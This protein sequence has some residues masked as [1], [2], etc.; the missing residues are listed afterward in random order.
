MLTKRIIEEP[1]FSLL[2]YIYAQNDNKG[3]KVTCVYIYIYIYIYILN[4]SIFVDLGY[5]WYFMLSLFKSL[6]KL[7]KKI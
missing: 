5:E 3:W 4:V 6:L 1:F 7:K 2:N